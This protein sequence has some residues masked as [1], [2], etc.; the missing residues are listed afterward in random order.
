[1]NLHA[2]NSM[3]QMQ[4]PYGR[5]ELR[6][7]G[8]TVLVDV[9]DRFG[10]R[11]TASRVSPER[12]VFSSLCGHHMWTREAI[13]RDIDRREEQKRVQQ[14]RAD[15]DLSRSFKREIDSALQRTVDGRDVLFAAL[16]NYRGG[17]R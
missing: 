6:R 12:P 17:A 16:A 15:A 10:N 14:E 9:I 2:I 4:T 3:P 7:V 1:M 8:K 11:G 5:M 13:F